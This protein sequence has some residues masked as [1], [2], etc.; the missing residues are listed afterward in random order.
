MVGQSW[1]FGERGY[2]PP[3]GVQ[4]SGK[5][6]VQIVILHDDLKQVCHW[7]SCHIGHLKGDFPLSLFSQWIPD[8]AVS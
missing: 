7:R 3:A 6:Q 8:S 2:F 1:H 5:C 4:E